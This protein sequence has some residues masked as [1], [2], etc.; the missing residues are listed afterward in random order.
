MTIGHQDL[1]TLII[2]EN[3]YKCDVKI[4]IKK[5]IY[6]QTLKRLEFII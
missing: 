5:K 2:L 1:P 4:K 6:K 3:D